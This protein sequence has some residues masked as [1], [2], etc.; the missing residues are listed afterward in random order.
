MWDVQYNVEVY[1]PL[2]DLSCCSATE[3]KQYILTKAE[4]AVSKETW[5]THTDETSF[6]VQAGSIW[7]TVVHVQ[8]AFIHI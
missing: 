2:I 7:M 6:I 8:Y 4:V 3:K 1:V 5:L